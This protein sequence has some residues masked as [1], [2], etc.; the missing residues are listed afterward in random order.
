ML[1]NTYLNATTRHIYAVVR[2]SSSANSSVSVIGLVNGVAVEYDSVT[3]ANYLSYF[4]G[5][6]TITLLIPP[7][8]QYG[9]LCIGGAC[10]LGQWL[11]I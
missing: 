2:V 4:A 11:E 3:D 5:H 10:T 7:G 9:V 6:R 8:Q 1:G